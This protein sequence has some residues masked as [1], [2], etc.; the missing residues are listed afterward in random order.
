M[1]FRYTNIYI[2]LYVVRYGASLV[3]Q[4]RIEQEYRVQKA[5]ADKQK[6]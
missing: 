6:L 5:A 4:S 3:W 2:I 1:F